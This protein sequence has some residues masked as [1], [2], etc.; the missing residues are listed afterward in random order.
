MTVTDLERQLLKS[1]KK[2]ELFTIAAEM[3]F[4]KLSATTSDIQIIRMAFDSLDNVGVPAFKSCSDLLAEFLVAGEVY[5][6]KGNLVDPDETP[7]PGTPAPTTALGKELPHPPCFMF[8]DD[9]DPACKKCKLIA[10]CREEHIKNRPPCY[11][12]SYDVTAVECQ[13]CI[14]AFMC[15]EVFQKEVANG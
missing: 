8:V 10:L 14:L 7:D 11:G 13:E 6:E 2:T 15:K 5:D 1:F 3:G 9:S 12:Q 4:K